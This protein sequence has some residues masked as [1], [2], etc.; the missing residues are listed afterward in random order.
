MGLAP[1]LLTAQAREHEDSLLLQLREERI[2]SNKLG[3][4]SR[5]VE[6]NIWTDAERALG[7]AFQA[8]SVAAQ[9]GIPSEIARAKNLI[10]MS[11]YTGKKRGRYCTAGHQPRQYGRWHRDRT[12]DQRPLSAA[13]CVP[14]LL[15]RRRHA[16]AGQAGRAHGLHRQT[17]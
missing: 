13:L 7:Y 9:A 11:Y 1:L 3:L 15:F 14:D 12:G 2:D 10:G 6:V 4:L 17:L 5:L 16:P 8:D